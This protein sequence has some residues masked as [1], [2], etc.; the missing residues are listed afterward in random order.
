MLADAQVD[1][2]TGLPDHIYWPLTDNLST[3]RDLAEY[4]KQT[5]ITSVVNHIQ[6]D[7]FGTVTSETNAAVDTIFGF[8]GR[9]SD[10]ESDLYYY[11]A[12]YYDPHLG[13]F[14]SEDPL[15]FEAKD[16]NLR[17]YVGNG[18]V[19]AM[20]PSGL[21]EREDPAG[22]SKRNFQ[23]AELLTGH[24][25]DEET[26]QE[27]F[28]NYYG[29][30]QCNSVRACVATAADFVNGKIPLGTSGEARLYASSIPKAAKGYYIDGPAEIAASG[31]GLAKDVA[32]RGPLQMSRD[33]GTAAGT[34]IAS[35][36]ARDRLLMEVEQSTVQCLDDPEK[37]AAVAFQA[38]FNAIVVPEIS[39]RSATA[40]RRLTKLGKTSKVNTALRVVDSAEDLVAPTGEFTNLGVLS[41]ANFSRSAQILDEATAVAQ[42]PTF[43]SRAE[44]LGF[45][46]SQVDVLP[47]RLRAYGDSLGE[48]PTGG[49]AN[50][51][52]FLV[53]RHGILSTR[54][55]RFAH[56]LGH[57]LD[58]I[59]NPGLFS[60]SA[61]P[62]FGFSGFYRAESVAYT[63]QYGFN[64]APL[65]A[66]NA[67]F[68]SNPV[69]T[70]AIVSAWC[71]R[72]L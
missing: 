31:Y 2:S 45:G 35:P 17:R 10:E 26:R 41:R 52:T 44:R 55:Q 64:P 54:T 29:K 12:R 3:V 60:R 1:P 28:D 70:T 56:E 32:T 42:S 15:G 20:D 22:I 13:Q 69:I 23:I 4:D 51:D 30:A 46:Q 72:R 40:I 11:R 43:V 19:D 37:G 8:T 67:G 65:S 47:G 7:A 62:G 5:G 14:A 57:V 58:D 63:L 39:V 24:V 48:I 71:L 59:A 53:G 34:L 6:Y 61:Q 21:E 27:L 49:F 16:P 9:E 66:L 68:Q 50:A 38:A 33:M 25:S 36:A 18:P